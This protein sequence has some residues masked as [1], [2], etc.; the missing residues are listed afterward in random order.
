LYLR[1]GKWLV[2]NEEVAEFVKF[3]PF[4]FIGIG[5]VML[6]DPYG[7]VQEIDKCVKKYGFKGIRVI[8]W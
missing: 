4:R 1:P 8:P 5:T 6:D 2:T 3:N 7:A